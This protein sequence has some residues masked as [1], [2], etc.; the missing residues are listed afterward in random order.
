VQPLWLLAGFLAFRFYDIAKPPPIRH[1][2]RTWQSPAGV[3]TDDLVAGLYA[4]LILQVARYLM[5]N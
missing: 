1:I 4:N 5:I 2:D 3:M